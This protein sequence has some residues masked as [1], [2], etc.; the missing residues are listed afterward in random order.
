[1]LMLGLL[2]MIVWLKGFAFALP[3]P[4]PRTRSSL[5]NFVAIIE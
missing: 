1:M 5:Y 3:P 4:G 2:M